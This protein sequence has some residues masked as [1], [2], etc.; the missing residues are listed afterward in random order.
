MWMMMLLL[1]CASPRGNQKNDIV[2]DSVGKDVD[3]RQYKKQQDTTEEKK[4]KHRH[5]TIHNAA[6]QN[7]NEYEITIKSFSV[8]G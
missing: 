8:F 5:H 7:Q 1:L 4:L 3:K 6:K 2:S